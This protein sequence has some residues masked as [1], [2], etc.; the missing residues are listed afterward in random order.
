MKLPKTVLTPKAIDVGRLTHQCP[1][2]GWPLANGGFCMHEDGE[3]YDGVP[4]DPEIKEA[5]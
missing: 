5:A 1:T 2:C 3:V 4:V